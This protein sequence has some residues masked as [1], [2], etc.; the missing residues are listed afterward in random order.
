[1]AAARVAGDGGRPPRRADGRAPR[2]RPGQRARGERE[3]L[4]HFK[5]PRGVTFVTELPKTATGKIQKFVL[6]D[7]A[8]NL[9]RQ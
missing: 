5:V 4:T 3:R 7:G 6:R 2:G 1:M 9:A 8:P